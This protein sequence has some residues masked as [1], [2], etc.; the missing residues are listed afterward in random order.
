M[1]PVTKNDDG[2]YSFQMPKSPVN[3]SV[4]YKEAKKAPASPEQTGVADWLITDEHPAFFSGYEDGS[5]RPEGNITRAEVAMIFYRLLKNQDVEITVSF[6]DVNNGDWY[7]VAVNTLASLKIITGYEDGTFAPDK[8]ISRA[9]FS[10]IATRF[11]K[12]TGGKQT[13]ADV[14]AGYW[15]EDNIATAYDYGW[16][17]GKGHNM[18]APLDKITR[19]EAAAII[20]RMLNRAAD[21]AYVRANGDKLIQ[22][23]D[24]QDSSK[25]YYLDMVEA[26][27]EHNFTVDNGVE[28]WK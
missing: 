27:N 28:T 1:I 25:W 5:I 22:F 21:E 2:T 24:L 13:F 4:T 8:Q 6:P 16:I 7:A 23:P 3:V 17:E 12:A 14:E 18:F 20:N 10:A 9:E 15:A 19:A 11:A 26:T